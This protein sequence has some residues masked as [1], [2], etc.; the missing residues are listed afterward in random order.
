MIAIH[1][2]SNRQQWW[3]LFLRRHAMINDLK[4]IQQ[5]KDEMIDI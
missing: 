3:L 2:S 4:L 5:D 1:R